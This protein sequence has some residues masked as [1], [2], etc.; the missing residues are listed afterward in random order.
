MTTPALEFDFRSDTVTQPSEDMKAAMMASPLGD[1]VFGEDPTVNALQD[2][3]ARLTGMEAALF[4]PTG[5]MANLAA[6]MGHAH[7]GTALFAGVSSHVKLYELGSYARIAGLNLHEID[8]S[9]GFL[10]RDALASAWPADLYFMPKPGLV[11]VENTHNMLGGLIYPPDEL[12]A[13]YDFTQERG[14]PLHMDGARLL[15]AARA[16]GV[17]VQFWTR[18]VDSVMIAI[19]KGLGA[20]AGSLL[21]GSSA[22]INN[23]LPIRKLLGG[24]MRQVGILAAAGL[25]SLKHHLPLLDRDHDRCRTV[26]EAIKDLEWLDV[27][28]PESNILIYHL[29][30]PI[31]VQYMND[32]NEQGIHLLALSET[33]VRVVFHLNLSDE[34]CERLVDLTRGWKGAL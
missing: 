11:T 33:K 6:L 26:F 23:V 29:K 16:R 30:K 31:A 21:A 13:L 19:S 20:P 1:D 22:F 18:H 7:P 25:F 15:N 17:D 27:I 10:D 8:D 32:L 2:E 28:N 3:V 34:A 5:S 9:R 24:G 4:F 14:T 12:K